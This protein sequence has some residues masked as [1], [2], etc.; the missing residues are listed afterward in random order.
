MWS[1]VVFEGATAAR[2]M[3]MAWA[4]A[5]AGLVLGK[6]FTWKYIPGEW[7]DEWQSEQG[8]GQKFQE[9]SVVLMFQDPAMATFY[10]LKWQR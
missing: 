8:H 4:L 1:E 5:R 3:E 10:S 9:K 7:K 6:D 2:G